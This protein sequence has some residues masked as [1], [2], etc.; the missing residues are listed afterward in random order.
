VIVGWL[1][2]SILRVLRE[3]RG[4]VVTVPE[5]IDAIYKHDPAGGPDYARIGINV[6]VKR[7][8]RKGEKIETV[9]GYRV[10]HG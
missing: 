5:L 6:T 10:P 4:E 8:R 1:A 2:D 7:M 9:I 3:R